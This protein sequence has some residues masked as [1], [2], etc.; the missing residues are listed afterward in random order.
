MQRV[1]PHRPCGAARCRRVRGA[2]AR[3]RRAMVRESRRD[4]RRA[5]HRADVLPRRGLN[6][7]LER[8]GDR[9]RLGRARRAHARREAPEPFGLLPPAPQRP[10]Q[11]RSRRRLHADGGARRH[12]VDDRRLQRRP[13]RRGRRPRRIGRLRPAGPGRRRARVPEIRLRVEGARLRAAALVAPRS[14]RKRRARA[15]RRGGPRDPQGQRHRLGLRLRREMAP[16]M[17]ARRLWQ[18]ALDRRQ[19]LDGRRPDPG[20]RSTT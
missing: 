11:R 14:G 3:L 17:P 20:P 4:E 10:V 7:R 8:L 16:R 12:Q 13:R 9:A 6:P 18:E 1:A 15:G 19:G 2:C 5:P